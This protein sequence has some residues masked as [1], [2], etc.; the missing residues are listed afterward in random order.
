[1]ESRYN[2]KQY[3]FIGFFILLI[4]MITKG[5]RF[6]GWGLIQRLS[7][8]RYLVLFMLPV[9]ALGVRNKSQNGNVLG[10]TVFKINSIYVKYVIS[11]CLITFFLRNVIYGGGLGY[12]LES[13]IFV[14]FVFSAYYIFHYLNPTEQL[15][16]KLLTFVGLVVLAIQVFQQLYPEMAIFSMFT[17]DMRQDLGL[18]QEYIT[19]MRNGLYRFM[20]I[21]QHFP[22]FLLCY[23]F[24]KL[25]SDYKLKTL[26][27]TIAF[28]V[29]TY[30]MLTRMFMICACIS[31]VF[32]YIFQKNR[33]KSKFIPFLILLVGASLLI[34]YSDVLF[35]QLFDSKDSDVDY[36]TAA[37][38]DCIPFM[39]E[40]SVSNPILL[41]TGHGYP[42]LLWKWGGQLGY[43]YNDIGI[44]GQIYPYGIIWLIVY[45]RIVYCFIIKYKK[46][47]PA[48]IRSYVFGL[49]CICTVMSSYA[50]SLD[51]TLLWVAVLYI[52][53]LY[54]GKSDRVEHN[55]I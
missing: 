45:L 38:M 7:T 12:G 31:C 50:N 4:L 21:A 16:I 19:G 8:I 40:Q 2:K 18:S 23:Y 39:L 34:S 28:A 52:A 11:T 35:A 29:S 26:L 5:L 9:W 6:S 43:W 13:N 41:I 3:I 30:L 55:A 24:S 17:E 46:N 48:Y 44:W 53:D 54:I 27:F 1:M 20:P 32:I 42:D 25:L 33:K 15:L 37:R 47:L 22:L 36:S 51:M 14:A 10:V 49:F